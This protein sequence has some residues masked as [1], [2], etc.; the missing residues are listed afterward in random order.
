MAVVV[1]TSQWVQ[2]FRIGA[3]AEAAEVDRLLALGE[4]VMVGVVYAELLCGARDETQ[5]RALE[6]QLDAL[7]FLEMTTA[8]WRDT[9]R[10]LSDLQQEGLTI[11]LPDAAIAA[12][13][14]EQ[15]LQVY[16]RDDHFQRIPG[17]ELHTV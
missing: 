5:F 3:S 16:T 13:A 6:Q 9:G 12:L 7:P 15:A 1:D 17:L 2:Y 11:P 4:V 10:I 8:T 14:L